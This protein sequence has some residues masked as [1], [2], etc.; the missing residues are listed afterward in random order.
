MTNS[1]VRFT[2]QVPGFDAK[3]LEV[4]VGHRWAVV[5]GIHSDSNQVAGSLRKATKV[6]R[7]IEVPFDVDPALAR[8]TLQ[9]GTLQIVLPRSQ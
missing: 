8:A 6:M 2:A 7:V 1:A 3:D 4:E 9:S 5:C